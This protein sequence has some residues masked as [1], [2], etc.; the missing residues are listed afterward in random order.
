MGR[1]RSRGIWTVR[2]RG[3][4]PVLPVP[5]RR[6]WSIHGPGMPDA[7]RLESESCG[8]REQLENPGL[9]RCALDESEVVAA[10]ERVGYA[11]LPGLMRL[12]FP[13]RAPPRGMS[14]LIQERSRASAIARQAIRKH[15]TRDENDLTLVIIQESKMRRR[16]D[17]RSGGVLRR[18]PAVHLASRRIGNSPACGS[19]RSWWGARRSRRCR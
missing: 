18:R 5:G 19:T 1:I 15:R 10:P 17:S 14:P 7:A 6:G 9:A 12:L 8:R 11:R 4:R 16:C 13:A 3:L 2:Q